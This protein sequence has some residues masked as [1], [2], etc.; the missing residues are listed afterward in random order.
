MSLRC[1]DAIVATKE[2]SKPLDKSTPNGT[3]VRLSPWIS[4]IG[5]CSWS[6]WH[7]LDNMDGKRHRQRQT[8]KS[9]W[10]EKNMGG[11]QSPSWR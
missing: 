2:E 8:P 5:L 10:N 9:L 1:R 3:L 4:Q 11:N 6:L 7:I